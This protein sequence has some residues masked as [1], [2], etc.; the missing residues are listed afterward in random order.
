MGGE[1]VVD[2]QPA[3]WEGTK[4][5]QAELS[6][7]AKPAERG[8]SL[9]KRTMNSRRGEHNPKQCRR[10]K[11]TSDLGEVKTPLPRA[12]TFSVCSVSVK[13]TEEEPRAQT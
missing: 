7:E 5:G 10:L 3:P 8:G 1:K 12:A 2:T 13:N 6:Q 9:C 4:E 11:S